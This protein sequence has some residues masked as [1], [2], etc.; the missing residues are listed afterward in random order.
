MN[1]ASGNGQQQPSIVPVA[2]AAASGIGVLGFVTLAGG[3]VLWRRFGEMGIPPD[4][5]VA[6]VPNAALVSTGAEFLLPALGFT[7]ITVLALVLIKVAAAPDAPVPIKI[8]TSLKRQGR[9]LALQTRQLTVRGRPIELS[10]ATIVGTL[11]AAVEIVIAAV[12]LGEI[13]WAAF[14]ILAAIAIACGVIIRLTF[15]HRSVAAAALVAFLAVGT[16]W[17]ARAYEKTSHELTVI[18]MAYS[19]GQAGGV[20]RVE[21]GYLVA[22]TSDRIWFASLAQTFGGQVNELREFP[23]EEADD[24]EIGKL[25]GATDARKVALRFVRNLCQRLISLH[26]STVPYGCPA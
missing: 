21:L 13:K 12:S 25:V 7:A 23:R 6:L 22:E 16:F 17:I 4:Q 10:W 1:N 19:R 14:V 24:L 2:A 20:T 9:M 11:V 3:V 5:A 18:P 26:P 8:A 15:L